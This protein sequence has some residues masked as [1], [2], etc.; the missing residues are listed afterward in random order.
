[1]STD[2]EET[3][4]RSWFDVVKTGYPPPTQL[5]VEQEGSI[6]RF[7]ELVL[8][9]AGHELHCSLYNQAV[10]CL[11][12]GKTVRRRLGEL[13][14]GTSRMDRRS[15]VVGAVHRAMDGSLL[16]VD[17]VRA[18][19]E[20]AIEL[21]LAGCIWELSYLRQALKRASEKES[22]WNVVLKLLSEML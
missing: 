18:V 22:E 9:D 2:E 13:G 1:M 10:D 4:V 7:L 6:T 8:T 15:I 19:V 12:K 11:R 5:N 3:V 20:L 21:C 14:D 17:L 16:E